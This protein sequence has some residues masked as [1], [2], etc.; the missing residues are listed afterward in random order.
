MLHIHDR[1]GWVQFNA[2]N[3]PAEKTLLWYHFDIVG[4]HLGYFIPFECFHGKS[5]FLTG[6]VTHWQ[7]TQAFSEKEKSLKCLSSIQTLEEMPPNEWLAFCP[8]SFLKLKLEQQN[9]YFCYEDAEQLCLAYDQ[10]SINTRLDAKT[11]TTVKSRFVANPQSP[12]KARAWV[13]QLL[14]PKAVILAPANPDTIQTL[15]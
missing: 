8:A 7:Y 14:K 5:G 15:G 1:Q 6:D 3:P 4:T 11:G 2:N 9:V 13:H 10:I 12:S